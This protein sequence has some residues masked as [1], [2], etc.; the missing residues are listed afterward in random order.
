MPSSFLEKDEVYY[1][2]GKMSGI[3]KFNFPRFM[4][5]ARWLRDAGYN[6][7][8]PAEIDDEHT[9]AQSIASEHGDLG[10]TDMTWGEALGRDVTIVADKCDA[11]ILMDE[12]WE[13]K[14]AMLEAF[15]ACL[16][17]K[18]LYE[19]NGGRDGSPLYLH[20][21]NKEAVLAIMKGRV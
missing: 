21:A 13:S 20:I 17:N 5:V 15:T 4:T 14:G 10:D 19:L 16:L 7:M 6:I 18:P 12:W 1:L 3:P 11:V 9:R 8:N 2:A